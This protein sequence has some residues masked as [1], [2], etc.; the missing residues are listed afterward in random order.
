[1]YTLLTQY[2]ANEQATWQLILNLITSFKFIDKEII[3]VKD[4]S[5]SKI[6]QNYTF[7]FQAKFLLSPQMEG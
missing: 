6:L 5:H 4:S 7:L 2:V 3:E 1:M